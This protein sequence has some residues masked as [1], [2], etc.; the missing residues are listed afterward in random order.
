MPSPHATSAGLPAPPQAPGPIQIPTYLLKVYWWAY[1]HPRAVRLFERPWLINAILFSNYRRL[2]NTALTALGEPVVHGRTLQ[3]ACV[4]GDLTQRLIRRLSPQARLDVIDILPVQLDN[5]RTKLEPD[6][7]VRLLRSDSSALSVP[8]AS[9]DQA[10][11]FFLL[12]EQPEPVRR[13]TLAEAIR[14]LR[15]GGKLVVIDYHRPARWHPLRPLM[16]AVF[17]R[18]E[19][20]AIDL[21]RAPIE[22]WLPENFRAA[23]VTRRTWMGGLY[24]TLEIVR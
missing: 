10:L 7:R 4:Y 3:I 24:Q 14:V 11:M 15:P 5:L 1:V 2:S 12:H 17:R 20:Y 13:A 16:W 23:S 21:W 8:D 19:P 6:P 18:L 22:H 9:Y